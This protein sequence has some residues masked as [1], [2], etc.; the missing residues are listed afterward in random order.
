VA[1]AE[2]RA[3]LREEDDPH[4]H[5][6]LG[7]ELSE[8]G[9]WSE[10]LSELR[11]A[12]QRGEPDDLLILRIGKLLETLN[13]PNQARLEYKRFLNS[14]LCTQAMPDKRCER[15]SKLIEGR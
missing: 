12:E 7:I 5:K 15:A 1:I 14:N 13:Q 4:T 3:A 10:A 6:L 9:Y 11:L 8:A 2:Y